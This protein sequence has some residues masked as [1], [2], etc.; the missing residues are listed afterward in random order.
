SLRGSLCDLYVMGALFNL[1]EPGHYKLVIIDAFYR[2]L[3]VGIDE[4][5][6]GAVAG[7]YNRIDQYAARMKCAFVLIHHTSKGNQSEKSVTD[8]GSGAGSQ[9]RAADTHLILRH[10]QEKD[11]VVLDAAVRSWPPVA[12]RC[13]RWDFPVWVSALHLDP[14]CLRGRSSG[15]AKKEKP[16]WY[17]ESFVSA[18]ITPEPSTRSEIIERAVRG[19][20][21]QWSADKLLRDADRDGLVDRQ[22]E[23]KR[24]EPYTYRRRASAVEETPS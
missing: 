1:V 23:G 5:D 3:P 10:H 20:L 16:S 22:G 14:T 7:L 6:N 21:S 4:N 11:V 8:V 2:T 24:S 18:F 17:P 15:G 9:S 19:G 12:P 13:L